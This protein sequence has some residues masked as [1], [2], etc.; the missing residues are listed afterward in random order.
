MLPNRAAKGHDP[1]LQVRLVHVAHVQRHAALAGA[2]RQHRIGSGGPTTAVRH[3]I[4]AT[5]GLH[6]KSW[7]GIAS[8]IPNI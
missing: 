5:A 6:G 8:Q 2:R 1:H 4:A 7:V 3:G